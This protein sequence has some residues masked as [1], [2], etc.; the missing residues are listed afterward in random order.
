MK[1]NK[2]A[3]MKDKLFPNKELLLQVCV[4]M[5]YELESIKR[6]LSIFITGFHRENFLFIT[7]NVHGYQT[8]FKL[9]CVEFSLQKLTEFYHIKHCCPE[10]KWIH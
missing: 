1:R 9:K 5:C 4:C 6:F 7:K 8:N 10:L 2:L 3:L